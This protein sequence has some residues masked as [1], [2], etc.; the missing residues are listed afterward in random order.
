[1]TNPFRFND[2]IEAM[3]KMH[4]DALEPPSDSVIAAD[5]LGDV[6]DH[7][8]GHVVDQAR[9]SGASWTDIGTSLGVARRA[10]EKRFVPKDSGGVSDLD[11]SQ[12]FGG[13]RSGRET[14][15]WR[16]RTKPARQTTT[17][18]APTLDVRA[19]ERARRTRRA[20][21]VAQGVTPE[22]VRQTVTATLPPAVDQVPELI[23]YD[24][25]VRNA[26]ELRFRQAPG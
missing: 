25:R 7:L 3:K 1:M 18:S 17:R 22:T 26:L 6:A 4:C 5:H 15:S 8:I 19:S 9:R 10:A 13:S 20:L 11:P 12:G 16:R 14:S 23:P 2:V 21:I 24:L